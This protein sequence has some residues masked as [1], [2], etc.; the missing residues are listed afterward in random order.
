MYVICMYIYANVVYI[1]TI[2]GKRDVA[3]PRVLCPP[4]TPGP[5]R[6]GGGVKVRRVAVDTCATPADK[7]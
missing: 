5:N 3:S 1:Y 4:A 2:N 7:T 6:E